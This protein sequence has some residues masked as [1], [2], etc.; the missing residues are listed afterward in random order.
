MA[1]RFGGARRPDDPPASA[2]HRQP[3]PDRI[4]QRRGP[5]SRGDDDVVGGDRA[6][7]GHDAAN[8]ASLLRQR[9][10]AQVV[11]DLGARRLR[12]ERQGDGQGRRIQAVSLVEEPARDRLRRDRRLGLGEDRRRRAGGSSRLAR[13][14]TSTPAARA[15]R[16][17]PRARPA[18]G[19][20]VRGRP[21]RGRPRT[22]RRPG[23]RGAWRGPCGSR[24]GSSGSTNHPWFLP[25]APAASSSRSMSVTLAPARGS[26]YAHAAP[27]IPPPTTATSGTAA[28]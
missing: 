28:D 12:R 8:G 11:P 18:G 7:V 9:A 20:R 16:L 26:S 27:T 1:E 22:R 21:R 10:D 25:E 2:A 23:T 15:R 19:R 4:Q 14:P 24:T 13:R 17:R 5:R 6:V 3:D